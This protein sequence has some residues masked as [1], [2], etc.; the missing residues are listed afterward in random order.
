MGLARN[1]KAST[2]LPNQTALSWLAPLGFNN[3]NDELIITKTIT[4]FPSELF[5]AAF[6]TKATDSRPVEIFRGST[7]VGLN[8]GTISASGNVLTDSGAS[9]PTLP[10]L[11]GRLIRDSSSTV[12][13]IVSNTATTITIDEA[14]TIANGKYVI[15]AD[16]PETARSQENYEVDIR[17]QATNGQISNLVIIS[18]GQLVVKSF[19]V[20]EL[21]NLIFQDGSGTKFII[22]DNTE[23]TVFFYETNSP[24][25]GAGMAILNSFVDSS[26]LPYI[27]NFRTEAEAAARTGTR[28]LDD[29]FYYYTV[30]TKLLNANVA[31]AEFATIESGTPT[32]AYAL[33]TKDEN[34]GELLYNLW[35]ELDRT[36]DTTEDLLDLMKVFGFQLNEIHS[37][38]K[39]YNLQDS[40]NVLVTALQPLSEQSG[41]PT[42][43]FS[44]GADTLRRIAREQISCWRLKGSKE[45]IAVFIREITTWDIT[46]GTADFSTAIQDVLP[47]VEALRFFDANLGNTNTRITETEPVFIPGGRFARGL[48]GIVIPGFFTFREFVITIPSVALYVGT[49]EAFSVSSNQTTMVDTTQNFGAVNSLVGNYLLPNQ[50]E[51]N[52]IFQIVANTSTSITV[53]GIVTNRNPGGKF[54]ILS[55]LNTNRFIIL[56]RLLPFY[57]PFGTKAGYEFT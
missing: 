7:I 20:G 25:I 13:R 14:D 5:N 54:A 16:F 36:L 47:N 41:L 31:Q 9:F 15:L 46:D 56:N 38:I 19:E 26:P 22:K 11:K 53:R 18:N 4:H 10:S 52:D 57:I 24:V 29:R 27:D 55:P 3:T 30:F 28:L 48:P 23:D 51:V 42:V 50:E 44:I 40:D 32:Q 17:T 8:T 12:H 33:S 45:G 49:S 21:A 2:D 6:P 43:G 39:T 37:L 34:F 35:P 1:F